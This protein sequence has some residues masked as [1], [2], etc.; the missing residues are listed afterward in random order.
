MNKLVLYNDEEGSEYVCLC[1][2]QEFYDELEKDNKVVGSIDID[3]DLTIWPTNRPL[4]AD[5]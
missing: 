5:F 1:T 4:S 2:D 3:E